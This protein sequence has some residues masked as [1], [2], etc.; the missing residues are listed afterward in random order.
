[1]NNNNT[2]PTGSQ[3]PANTYDKLQACLLKFAKKQYGDAVKLSRLPRKVNPSLFSKISEQTKK[4][5]SDC[6]H[7]QSTTTWNRYIRMVTLPGEV[8]LNDE[9]SLDCVDELGK[10]ITEKGTIDKVYEET[11]KNEEPLSTLKSASKVS[12]QFAIVFDL[13]PEICAKIIVLR[14][15]PNEQDPSTPNNRSNPFPK[16]PD[17][18]TQL[19]N[20]NDSMLSLLTESSVPSTPISNN[21]SIPKAPDTAE[22][23]EEFSN[24]SN[25]LSV[26]LDTPTLPKSEAQNKIESEKDVEEKKESENILDESTVGNTAMSNNTLETSNPEKKPEPENNNIVL[27]STP[28]SLNESTLG[29]TQSGNRNL[30]WLTPNGKLNENNEDLQKSSEHVLAAPSPEKNKKSSKANKNNV[31]LG[32]P[33]SKT[34]PNAVLPTVSSTKED[35]KPNTK[36]DSTSKSNGVIPVPEIKKMIL[37]RLPIQ[38]SKPK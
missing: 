19:S 28:T 10:A 34:P 16:A 15:D 20:L 4:L 13:N 2:I 30:D 38:K 24:V 5:H 32:T 18:I 1:M 9:G 36:A 6:K 22:L 12:T 17:T 3:T 31:P 26:I 29:G 33:V 14:L 35:P 25:S 11:S 27:N 23:E 8:K 37:F 7:P 21:N